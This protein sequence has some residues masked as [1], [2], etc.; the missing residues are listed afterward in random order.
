VTRLR[1]MMLEELR[2]RNYAETTIDC[3][4]RAVE[5]FSRRFQIGRWPVAGVV[6]KVLINVIVQVKSCQY[7]MSGN[8]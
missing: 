1:K 5:D 2:R 6:A 4:I 7:H 8:R 3:Y